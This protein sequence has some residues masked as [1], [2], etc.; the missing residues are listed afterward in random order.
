MVFYHGGGFFGGEI[1]TTENQ[2]RLLAELMK[3]VVF[4]VDYP[5]CP[6]TPYPGGFDACWN[7]LVTVY[8]QAEQHNID[9]D[10]IGVFG[11][12]AGGNFA[13][14]VSMR[15]RNE[16]RGMVSYQALIYPTVIRFVDKE[17][18]YWF[19]DRED[20][21]IAEPGDEVI[22]SA[23]GP[24]ADAELLN[25]WYVPNG[26]DR[27]DPYQNPIIDALTDL[28]RTLV[29]AAEYDYLRAETEGLFRKLVKAGNDARYIRYGGIFHGTFDRLGYAP[30]VEDM[31]REIA[32]DMTE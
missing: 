22:E 23:V 30:Q 17:G 26:V 8:E 1:P 32:K 21:D 14:I 3:G 19:W 7:A 15:D 4:S 12:S 11:D 5:L 31:L 9:R 2:C 24:M 27:E 13:L 10:R 16:G 28:P 20:F 25:A 18:P 29:M 6:E